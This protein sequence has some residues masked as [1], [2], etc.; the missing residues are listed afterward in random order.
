MSQPAYS[1][2][3]ANSGALRRTSGLPP[4]GGRPAAREASGKRGKISRLLKILDNRGGTLKK[5]PVLVFELLHLTAAL[6]VLTGHLTA[7]MCK[8]PRIYQVVAFP[9]RK[10]G[11]TA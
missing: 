8:I 4:E 1:R 6:R 2:F 9:R 3:R 7:K 5:P 11:K 10:A